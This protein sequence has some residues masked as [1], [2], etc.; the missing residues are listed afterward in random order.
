VR[1]RVCRVD[2]KQMWTAP[3]G[4]CKCKCKCKYKYKCDYEQSTKGYV[5]GSLGL[6]SIKKGRGWRWEPEGSF[7]ESRLAPWRRSSTVWR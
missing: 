3:S 6:C 5:V 4:E 7:G 1:V 2:W